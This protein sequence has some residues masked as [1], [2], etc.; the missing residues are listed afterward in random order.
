MSAELLQLARTLYVID[1]QIKALKEQRDHI[2]AELA[3]LMPSKV[4]EL[5]GLGT[6]ERKG[7]K[8]R[9]AWMHDDLFRVLLAR[10]RD[11]RRADPETGEYESPEEAAVRVIREC[12]GVGYWRVEPLRKRGLS[13]DEY[14]TST[15]A[16][17]TVILREAKGEEDAA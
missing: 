3:A 14:C 7:G 4:V 11:E 6:L 16:P 2:V 9:K 5:P 10:S 13:V 12:A 1:A 15:P 17:P 8:D